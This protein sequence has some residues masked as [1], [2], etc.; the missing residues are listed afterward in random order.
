MCWRKAA[1]A[2]SRR[3]ALAGRASV[4]DAAADKAQFERHCGRRREETARRTDE[5]R[6]TSKTAAFVTTLKISKRRAFSAVPD[7]ILTDRRLGDRAVRVLA[8]LVG[9]PDGWEVRVGYLRHLFDLSEEQWRFAR[10]QLEAAGYFSQRRVFGRDGKV[11]W[12]HE[13][14]DTGTPSRENRGMEPS[15]RNPWDGV[16]SHGE[17]RDITTRSKTNEVAAAP[18][19][20]ACVRNAAAALDAGKRRRERPTGI[21]TWDASDVA[22]AER[23]EANHDQSAVRAAASAIVTAGRE[24]V[25]GLVAAELVDMRR[26]AEHQARQVADDAAHRQ[27]LADASH[28]PL[29]PA[30]TAV[31]LAAYPFLRTPRKVIT[32]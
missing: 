18:H 27:R 17:V 6:A 29:D 8:W 28:V 20:R 22:E 10:K 30:A 1:L 23:I 26:R 11:R 32:T 24:P 25:P 5:G 31:A 19:A 7:D 13:I 9:R 14:S 4:D 3:R 15:P 16:P 2:S 12:E 21:V